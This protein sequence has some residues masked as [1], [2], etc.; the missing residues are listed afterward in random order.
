[1]W[2]ASLTLTRLASKLQR[3][4]YRQR[5]IPISLGKWLIFSQCKRAPHRLSPKRNKDAAL[6]SSTDEEIKF[7]PAPP[8]DPCAASSPRFGA[9]LRGQLGGC[10]AIPGGSPARGWQALP[11]RSRV[12]HSRRE[13][14]LP[15]PAAAARWRERAGPGDPAPHGRQLWP[16]L[17][18][19]GSSPSPRYRLLWKGAWSQRSSPGYL[20]GVTLLELLRSFSN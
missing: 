9:A 11:V 17:S 10:R 5:A 4:L 14:P 1:M 8:A 2:K 19:P 18:A 6:A 7:K 12:P 3:A 13:L 16:F 20:P 15:R